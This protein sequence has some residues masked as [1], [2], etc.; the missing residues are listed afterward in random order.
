MATYEVTTQVEIPEDFGDFQVVEKKVLEAS[1]EAGRK[2]LEQIFLAYEKD[3]LS[4]GVFQ[5]HDC[6]EKKYQTL[7]GVIPFKR[8]RV[9]AVFKGK[10]IYPLDEWLDLGPKQK[11]SPGLKEMLVEQVVVRPYQQATKIVEKLSGVK[12]SVMGNWKMIQGIGKARQEAMR[13]LPDWSQKALPELMPSISDPC[14]VLGTDPDATYAKPRRKVDKNHE[15]K[16]AVMYTHR[17]ATG[18]KKK[19]WELGN[20]QVVMGL[21]REP[22]EVLFNRVTDKAVNDYGLHSASR[23]IV[24][25]DGDPWIKQFQ[26]RY[27][28]QAL[29]RLDPWHVFKKIWEETGAEKIPEDWYE[30]FYTNPSSLIQKIEGLGKE[31]AEGKDKERIEQLVGYLKNNKEGMAPSGVSKEIKERFPRMYKRGSGTI[32]SNIFQAICQRFKA[33]RMMWSEEGLN[34]L[35]RLREEYLNKSFGFQKV[36]VPKGHYRKKTYADEL[37]EIAKDLG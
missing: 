10:D 9:W 5:K 17:K 1:R 19:R 36:V 34:N 20:K 37:R 30:D 16:M 33:P 15:L 25:G 3:R 32:E 18:R 27:C 7:L 12:R 28:P 14:P 35:V 31:M 8:Q 21:V 24:H 26:D 4:K 2:V 29:N 22:A 6:P 11:V 13:R 23:V